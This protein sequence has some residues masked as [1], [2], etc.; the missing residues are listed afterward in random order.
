M[1]SPKIP[2]LATA[3]PEARPPDRTCTLRRHEKPASRRTHGRD[4]SLLAAGGSA[5]PMRVQ[6]ASRNGSGRRGW[7]SGTDVL[8]RGSEV[9][10]RRG[11]RDAGRRRR[12]SCL[13]D[14]GGGHD[15]EMRWMRTPGRGGAGAVRGDS[16]RA[17]G[18]RAAPI[19]VGA[20]GRARDEPCERDEGEG[21]LEAAGASSHRLRV[22][23]TADQAAGLSPVPATREKFLGARYVAAGCATACRPVTGSRAQAVPPTRNPRGAPAVGAAR[24]R[25]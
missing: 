20:P 15:R 22:Y 1:S 17:R 18:G 25:S 10:R 23:R 7:A 24:A 6:G 19:V 8:D 5:R 21:R 12:R 16:P 4:G 3:G 14:A 2:L 11:G 9:E 13:R